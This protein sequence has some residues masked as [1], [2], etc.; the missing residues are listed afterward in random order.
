[1]QPTASRFLCQ[2]LGAAFLACLFSM[3]VFARQ[4]QPSKPDNTAQ[5]S[6]DVKPVIDADGTYHTTWG[7]E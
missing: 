5:P 6:S 1:M 3:P 2:V 7:M 4:Q